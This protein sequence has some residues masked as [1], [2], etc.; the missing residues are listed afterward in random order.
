MIKSKTLADAHHIAAAT[1]AATDVTSVKTRLTKRT[2]DVP[3]TVRLGCGL[4]AK[5]QIQKRVQLKLN[6]LTHTPDEVDRLPAG[7]TPLPNALVS[8]NS[9]D[10]DTLAPEKMRL[11]ASF[12]SAVGRTWLPPC[13]CG[14]GSDTHPAKG[15]CAYNFTERSWGTWPHVQCAKNGQ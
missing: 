10:A 14:V 13:G 6:A 2:R 3:L 15:A 4:I 5:T 7:E 1:S 12:F 8:F 11:Q 9:W